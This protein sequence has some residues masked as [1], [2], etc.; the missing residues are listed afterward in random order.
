MKRSSRVTI[1]TIVAASA[2]AVLGLLTL[3]VWRS[4]QAI[5][6]ATEE[7]PAGQ[8]FQCCAAVGGRVESGVR[9]VSPQPYLFR[10]PAF[11]TIFRPDRPG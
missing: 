11:R 10:R 5:R 3:V 1:R 9:T 2:V 7:V 4:S 8:D 6:S